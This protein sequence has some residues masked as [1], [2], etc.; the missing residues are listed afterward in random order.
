MEQAIQIPEDLRNCHELITKTRHA[1]IQSTKTIDP[2]SQPKRSFGILDLHISRTAL[3][4]ALR[5]LEAVIRTCETRGWSVLGNT[6][7]DDSRIQIEDDAVMFTM[8][9]Q[10]D[11]VELPSTKEQRAQPY[12]RSNWNYEYNGRLTL[13]LTDWLPNG[14]RRTWSDGKKQRL[15][16]VL[17]EF[18]EGVEAACQSNK[19]RRLER[20]E[21]ERR[22]RGEESRREEIA[23][24]H[25][26][27]TEFFAQCAGRQTAAS[28]RAMIR[29]VR[30]RSFHA[31]DE[32]QKEATDRWILWA[33]AVA[34]RVDPFANGYFKRALSCADLH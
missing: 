15:E 34:N 28:L 13:Q 32:W 19:V 7:R 2:Y 8:F 29:E 33:E 16:N 10:R 9:E 11:R 17:A 1:C 18:F 31:P 20:E 27:R 14:M 3:Q 21:W 25:S 4:R 22:Y 12:W 23:G 24:E 30:T 5:L 6:E 26:R